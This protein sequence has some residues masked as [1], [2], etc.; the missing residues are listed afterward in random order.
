M[1][2]AASARGRFD[3]VYFEMPGELAPRLALGFCAEAAGDLATAAVHYGR[4][5]LVDPGQASASFGLA[6]VR[7]A[8]GDSAGAVEALAEI[9]PA[10]GLYGQARI[11]MAHV[12]LDGDHAAHGDFLDQAGTVI[13]SLTARDGSLERLSARLYAKAVDLI[14]TGRRKPDRSAMLLGKP[15]TE[16]DMRAAAEGAMIAAA[17]RADS[18]GERALWVDLAQGIRPESLL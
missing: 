7:Q 17:R 8:S 11:A 6:R 14:G 2:Q 1:H 10:H 18:P 3:R 15:L 9:P 16:R 4:V 12:L 13:G 5:T